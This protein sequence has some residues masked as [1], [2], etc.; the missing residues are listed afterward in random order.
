[1]QCRPQIL[2]RRVSDEPGS[3]DVITTLSALSILQRDD[4]L[5]GAT[6][7]EIES[8]PLHD[9]AEKDPEG[10]TD[11]LLVAHHLLKACPGFS[12]LA[13]AVSNNAIFSFP[14]G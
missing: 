4:E 2:L 14:A 13:L 12:V 8:L 6:L 7:D 10:Q 5:L 3:M 9:K 11:R 1:M